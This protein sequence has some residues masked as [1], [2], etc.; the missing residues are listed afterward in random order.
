MGVT[1]RVARLRLRQLRL[2]CNALFYA[3]LL[4]HYADIKFTYI[5]IVVVVVVIVC[6]L[7]TFN[8]LC[9]SHKMRKCSGSRHVINIKHP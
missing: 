7:A 8:G 5:V 4:T 9:D 1:Q 3:E 2:V 6:C